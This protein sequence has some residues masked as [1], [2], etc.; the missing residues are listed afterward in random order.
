MEYKRKLNFI[1]IL[2]LMMQFGTYLYSQNIDFDINNG[3]LEKRS[4]SVDNW[5]YGYNDLLKDLKDWNES[6]YINIDSIGSSVQNRALW[7]LKIT[8]ENNDDSKHIIY[9]HTRTHPNEVQSFWVVNEIIKFLI[10]DKELAEK[11]REKCI[12]YIIPMYNPDG[13]E[14]QLPRQ[15]ANNID[16]ESNWYSDD[17]QKEVLALKNRFIELMDSENPIEI[18][19][20]MHSAY[21][22][23]RYF[24]YHH[25]NGTSNSYSQIEKRF[26]NYVVSYFSDGFQPWNFIVTWKNGT[27]KKYP[28]SWWWLNHGKSVLALTYEDGNCAEAGSYDKTAFAI[29]SGISNY[30][31]ITSPV[32]IDEYALDN[33]ILEQSY[34]NPSKINSH[35]SIK[36]NIPITE[37][38]KLE[39]FNINGEKI[40]T[41]FDGIE[42]EGWHNKVFDSYR[43][44]PGNYFYRLTSK[45]AILTKKMIIL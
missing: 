20:N 30:F 7:E 4:Y 3:S 27:P 5:G 23:K 40:K 8:S 2:I 14:L 26:I 36:Y 38:I 24:V 29:L 43:L 22:C 18:A 12:F 17:I 25:E 44:N 28:E 37:R 34:P 33:Y 42:N 19:L 15:N 21:K 39:L 16:I 1:L 13:V 11:L 45:N 9:I 10:S 31:G 35:I 41:L 6:E 32:F